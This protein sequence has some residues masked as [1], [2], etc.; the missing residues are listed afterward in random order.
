MSHRLRRIDGGG[1][2]A[3]CAADG[4]SGICGELINTLKSESLDKYES[5]LCRA[6]DEG[7]SISASVVGG[8]MRRLGVKGV[9]ESSPCTG[10][11][12][13]GVVCK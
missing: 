11:F 10:I 7:Y 1:S 8:Y 5:F 13:I 3:R 4:D 2:A 9:Q 12:E 6:R